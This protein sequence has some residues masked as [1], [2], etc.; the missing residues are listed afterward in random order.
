MLLI[1]VNWVPTIM[2]YSNATVIWLRTGPSRSF[3]NA[4]PLAWLPTME[5]LN[6]S[7]GVKPKK[8]SLKRVT[9]TKPW[10]RAIENRYAVFLTSWCRMVSLTKGPRGCLFM[11]RKLTFAQDPRRY[12]K[13]RYRGSAL[14]S[15]AITV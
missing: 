1:A 6:I 2:L 5:F 14:S 15:F 13:R 3:R 7:A 4:V 10:I 8:G 12:P 11:F 9:L